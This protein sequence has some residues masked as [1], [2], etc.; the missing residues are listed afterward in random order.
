MTNE[1]STIMLDNDRITV[2]NSGIRT[3]IRSHKS[4]VNAMRIVRDKIDIAIAESGVGTYK[5]LA[6]K[7][8]CKPQGLSQ[9]ICRGHCLP[10][11]AGKIARALGVPVE[12][13]VAK[14]D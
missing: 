2:Y 4:E 11:S 12:T 14:E 8:G 9:I 10:R 6:R 13:I 1:K 3:N 7:I 5:N